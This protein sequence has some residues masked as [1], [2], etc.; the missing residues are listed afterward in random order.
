MDGYSTV[1][2]FKYG[3]NRFNKGFNP[4]PFNEFHGYPSFVVWAMMHGMG[5]VV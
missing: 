5:S 1:I 4:S 2:P 3:D